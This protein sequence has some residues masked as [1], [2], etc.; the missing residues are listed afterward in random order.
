MAAYLQRIAACQGINEEIPEKFLLDK[1]CVSIGTEQNDDLMIV[2]PREQT[3][4]VRIYEE[5]GRHYLVNQGI[6]IAVNDQIV[7]E[8]CFLSDQDQITIAND[9]VFRFC[10]DKK[11]AGLRISFRT[12]TPTEKT[13]EISS[14]ESFQIAGGQNE[15]Y[16][17]ANADKLRRHGQSDQT[18]SNSKSEQDNFDPKS[19]LRIHP[20]Q[21]ELAAPQAIVSSEEM[22]DVTSEKTARISSANLSRHIQQTDIGCDSE[23]HVSPPTNPGDTVRIRSRLPFPRKISQNEQQAVDANKVQVR[24]PFKPKAATFLFKKDASKISNGDGVLPQPDKLMPQHNASGQKPLESITL[25]RKLTPPPPSSPNQKHPPA[26]QELFS[27]R[28]AEMTMMWDTESSA[29]LQM[30]AELI[31][32]AS[33]QIV[34][35]DKEKITI[36]RSPAC[37]LCLYDEYV[38]RQHIEISRVVLGFL[39]K[40]IGKNIVIV[41]KKKPSHSG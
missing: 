16:T 28:E 38:S 24:L 2:L 40:N 8:R 13:G 29:E 5:N 35:L 4:A 21:T 10:L 1:P 6:K 36:G 17:K 31:S 12:K 11:S 30:V 41:E 32:P 26:K 22:P 27:F 15:N 3:G 39:V 20:V 34:Y 18:S 37:D 19:T 25:P 7:A 14:P 23:S 33:G 9:Y